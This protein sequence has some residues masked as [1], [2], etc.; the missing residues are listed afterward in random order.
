VVALC[1]SVASAIA[2]GSVVVNSCGQYI[3]VSFCSLDFRIGEMM[4]PS[5][6]W[7]STELGEV[8]WEF[9]TNNPVGSASRSGLIGWVV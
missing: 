6:A 1:L 4:H 3:L 7:I 9:I 5:G 2:S 8:G